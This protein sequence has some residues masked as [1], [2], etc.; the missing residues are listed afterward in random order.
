MPFLV[1]AGTV[2]P[3]GITGMA[4]LLNAAADDSYIQVTLPFAFPFFG[5]DRTVF[6]G[7]NSYLTFGAGSSAYSNLS[8]TVP[9]QALLVGGADNSYQRVYTKDNGDGSFRIRYE[10]AAGTSGTPGSPT[11]AWEAT[12]CTDGKILLAVGVH[13]RTTGVSLISN[14]V[15]GI[16]YTLAANQSYVFEPAYSAYVVHTGASLRASSSLDVSTVVEQLESSG[17]TSIVGWADF[18]P[19]VDAVSGDGEID[20]IVCDGDISP[21]LHQAESTGTVP[22][23]GLGDFS[24]PIEQA[25]AAG[26][27]P[28][29]GQGAIVPSLDAVAAVA[30]GIT[31]TGEIIPSLDNVASAGT[32]AVVRAATVEQKKPVVG[33]TGSTSI[34]SYGAVRTKD[35]KLDGAGRSNRWVGQV[36]F[37]PRVDVVSSAG[38]NSIIG[39]GEVKLNAGKTPN[40]ESTGL[41]G[42]WVGHGDIVPNIESVASG[43]VV[44]VTGRGSIDGIKKSTVSAIGNAS[45][46]GNADMLSRIPVISSRG[47]HIPVG[48]VVLQ[49]KVL[50]LS[51]TGSSSIKG[52]AAVSPPLSR[53]K[54]SRY[55][56]A[57]LQSLAFGRGSIIT[58]TVASPSI[59][60]I[61]FTR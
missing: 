55:A 19:S 21:P 36:A 10:G 41:S 61:H 42:E 32:S 17:S 34:I 28:V 51:S 56:K 59:E 14:G 3:L 54:A 49:G 25:N 6:V 15:A 58:G 1:T 40:I 44:P 4:L 24:P 47:L 30:A 20:L 38:V 12:L 26:T 37:E 2:A 5:V 23:V 60:P 7:S 11:I 39:Y 22:V 57:S 43:G 18:A 29:T 48:Q 9:G 45:I 53:V 52:I 16:P 8:A 50:H 13:E 35:C 33:S 31:A 46:V 27:I